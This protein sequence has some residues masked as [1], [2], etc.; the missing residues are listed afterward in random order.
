MKQAQEAIGDKNFEMK[1]YYIKKAQDI[2]DELLITLN[3]EYEVS[4]QLASLYRYMK[5]R[6][7]TANFKMDPSKI[8]EVIELMTDLKD[9]WVEA[10]KSIHTKP[11]VNL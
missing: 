9:T 5:E 3:Y 2:I 1:N 10:M 8:A 7:M 4:N 6:L 11:K